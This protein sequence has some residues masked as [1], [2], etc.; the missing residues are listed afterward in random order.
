MKVL[1]RQLYCISKK[2]SIPKGAIEGREKRRLR[3]YL[4]VS[5]PKGAIEGLT[6]Q[7]WSKPYL[8]VSIP[9]GAIEG[10]DWVSV[11]IN[12]VRFQYQKVRLKVEDTAST[13]IVLSSFNTK[14][15]D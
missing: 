1:S 8:P 6:R 14:R 11:K 5:I 9:K 4:L 13:I 10:Y 15:C 2:V 3:F 7:L 12:S